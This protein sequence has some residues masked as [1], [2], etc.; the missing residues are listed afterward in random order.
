M[1][2]HILDCDPGTNRYKTTAVFE[3]NGAGVSGLLQTNFT[4]KNL[5]T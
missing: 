2:L 4:K 3:R 5:D 1:R